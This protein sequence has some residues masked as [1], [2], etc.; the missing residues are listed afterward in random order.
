MR[1]TLLCLIAFYLYD[2][3]GYLIQARSPGNSGRVEWIDRTREVDAA[4]D[5][6][7]QNLPDDGPI[8]ATN[9]AL[10]YMRTGRKSLAFDNPTLR[11]DAWKAR[12]FRY[13]VC[14]HPLEMPAGAS[15]VL[16]QSPARF[17]VIKL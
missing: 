14:L 15:K 7:R 17:W 16:Y 10:L 5:W 12:G 11:L 13:V 3:A 8:A 1:V 2:H 6:I 9:S 4:L